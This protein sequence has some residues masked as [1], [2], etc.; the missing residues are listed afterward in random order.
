LDGA[1]TIVATEILTFMSEEERQK[2]T[3]SLQKESARK[4]K[5]SSQMHFFS[6]APPLPQ[7]KKHVVNIPKK[8]TVGIVT[9]KKRTSTE[10]ADTNSQPVSR[11]TSTETSP[12]LER[13]NLTNSGSS[14]KTDISSSPPLKKLKTDTTPTKI[15]IANNNNISTKVSPKISV[16][17]I[18]SNNGNNNAKL[19]LVSY[20]DEE[21]E[22]KQQSTKLV[23][24]NEQ[25]VTS[26]VDY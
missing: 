1:T 3:D 19:P 22:K 10:A 6:H 25:P 11:T 20:T 24:K 17:S 16:N 23:V 9:T 8:P 12:Q 21:I 2:Q 5:S 15:A 18:Q 14:G 13:K 7:G 4:N 26:L